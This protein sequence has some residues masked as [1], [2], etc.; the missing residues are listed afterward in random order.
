MLHDALSEL[1]EDAARLLEGRLAAG[2]E[3]PFEVGETTTAQKRRRSTALYAYRPLTA[4]F[5]ASHAEQLRSLEAFE[6]AVDNLARTHG[7]V[8]YL[9]SRG[10]PVLEVS[11]STHARLAVLAFLAAVWDDAESFG[12]FDDRFNRAY[13]ELE[14]VVLA[15]RLVTTAFIPVHGVVIE[16]DEVNLGDGV[17]LVA[18]EAPGEECVARFADEPRA[19]DCYCAVSIDAPSDAP[20]PVS[21]LRHEARCALTALRLFKPG[22]VSFGLTAHTELAGT[23]QVV[24]MPFSGRAREE[25]WRLLDGEDEEL[26]QFMAAVRRVEKRTR[27]SWALKRFEMG[28]ERTVPAEGLTDYLAAARALLNADDDAGKA[29]LPARIAALCARQGERERVAG[30]IACA[31]ALESLA[32]AGTVG[33]E[34]RK[35]L[36]AAAPLE[37]IGE[38]ESCLR[39][40]LHDLVCGYLESDLRRIAD[41]ILLSDGQVA[42]VEEA[43]DREAGFDTGYYRPADDLAA[44]EPSG[45][46][47]SGTL[48]FDSVFDD[49]AEISAADLR[50]DAQ[51]DLEDG[52]G[53]ETEAQADVEGPGDQWTE[54]VLSDDPGWWTP[55]QSRAKREEESPDADADGVAG[56]DDVAF[57]QTTQSYPEI[58]AGAR[59]DQL[60]EEVVDRFDRA[61]DDSPPAVERERDPEQEAR[62]SFTTPGETD[63]TFDFPV[64][65]QD[66]PSRGVEGPLPLDP[67]Q[68]HVDAEVDDEGPR[69]MRDLSPGERIDFLQKHSGLTGEF[70]V[71]EFELP[72]RVRHERLRELLGDHVDE[73]ASLARIMRPD[74]PPA[75]R[76]SEASAASDRLA[77]HPSEPERPR[78]VA[79]R[80]GASRAPANDEQPLAPVDVTTPASAGPATPA[81]IAKPTRREPHDTETTESTEPVTQPAPADEPP[82]GEPDVN[83]GEARSGGLGPATIEFRPLVD[84]D[85]DD[86]DDFA[87]A[88]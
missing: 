11:G 79:L 52:P 65:A 69:A 51:A 85:P 54:Q 30:A 56:A 84:G 66:V 25:A 4:E 38:V 77:L 57:E 67:R 74:N 53:T 22:S 81:P 7:A 58:D 50:D 8:A 75:M 1:T 2:E 24:T 83:H 18:P 70:P 26:R 73:K 46:A 44:A 55:E 48:E 61:L 27:T 76:A 20:L 49:T 31:F 37:I 17:Q 15:A 60:A 62:M 71:P 36:A 45:D 82:T 10:E 80:G 72:D 33:K 13:L 87:G 12:E 29:A 39:A 68:P 43:I 16:V 21:E 47:A 6:N 28:L 41:E 19:A 40:L 86:P 78:L 23:W 42:S 9:R 3:I 34:D 14:S 32:I 59:I 88:V 5:V 64:L 35:R 63:L